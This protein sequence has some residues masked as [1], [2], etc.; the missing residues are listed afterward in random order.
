MGGVFNTV[1]ASLYHYAGNNP[2]KYTDPDGKFDANI[3]YQFATDTAYK[4]Q[5][6]ALA[7]GPAPGPCDVFAAGMLIVAL[8]SVAVGGGIDLYN[9]LSTKIESRSQS[10]ASLV[11]I[12]KEQTQASNAIRFQLQTGSNTPASSVRISNDKLGVKKQEAYGALQELYDK[13]ITKEPGLAK[14]KDFTSAIVRMSE[15]VKS[16]SGVASG[17]NVMRETFIYQRK[18]YRIDLENLRGI[19]LVE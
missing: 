4:A 12:S 10:K 6:V 2:V 16:T 19:N 18:E 14:C 5:T 1:N 7:D 15:F 8:G 13:A 3:F 17:G 11:A 9:Y